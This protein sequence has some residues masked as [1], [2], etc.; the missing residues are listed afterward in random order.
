MFSDM[1]IPQKIWSYKSMGDMYVV[2]SR[3]ERSGIAMP[4]GW[5]RWYE[6][7]EISAWRGVR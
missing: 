2:A 1:H 6:R 7:A 3:P 5:E 4:G